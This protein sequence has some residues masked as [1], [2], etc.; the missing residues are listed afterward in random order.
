MKTIRTL[1]LVVP[2][3]WLAPG[4]GAQTTEVFTF[5]NLNR[6]VPDGTPAGLAD[7]R[8]VN[9]AIANLVSVRVRL[10]VTGSFSGDLYAYVLHIN[11]Q[12]TN[13]CVLLNRVGRRAGNPA[14][15]ND[16]GLNVTFD[17][18]APNDI[19]LYRSITTPAL[20]AQ[21]TGSW[22]P[23][24]RKVDPVSVLDSSPRTTTL[25]SFA[26]TSGDGEWTLFLADMDSGASHQL[27]S[28][29]LELKG[30]VPPAISWVTPADIV[31]GTALGSSQLNASA[32]AVAGTYAYTPAAG[33]ILNAG[34]AQTLSVLFTP[35]DTVN[36]SPATATVSLNVLKKNLLVRGDSTNKAY[37][38]ANPPLT[39]TYIGFI[40][41]DST[42]KLTNLA[43]VTTPATTASPAGSYAVT[44]S[45]LVSSNYTPSYITGTLNITKVPLSITADADISTPAVDTFTKVYNG[46]A[47]SPFTV[48]YSGFVN[49][50]TPAVLGGTLTF[51]GPGATADNVG[52]GY[53]VTPGG[54]TSGNY[55]ITFVSGALNITKATLTVTADADIST[56]AVDTFSKVYNGAS[57][58]P[59][60]VRYS[61]FVNGETP[62]VL[63]GTLTFSGP[64][65]AA[66]N[67]GTGYTVTPGG[68][69]SSNYAITFVS[70][71]LNITKAPLTIT[72]DADITTPAVDTFTK[73]YNGLTFSPFTVRYS[74]FVNSETPAVLSGALTFSGPAVAAVNAG[75]GY[76][77]MPG[78]LTSGNYDITF[79][80]GAL[81]ITKALLTITPNNATK[82]FGAPLPVFTDTYSGWVGSDGIGSLTAP[83]TNSTSAT[84]ISPAGSYAITPS[85]AVST[86]YAFDYRTG[87]LT[88]TKATSAAT[89][90]SSKNPAPLGAQVTFTFTATAVAPG[91]GTPDGTV[92]FRVD[93]TAVASPTLSGGSAQYSSSTLSV[94]THTITADYAGSDN[95]LGTSA[96]LSPAQLINTVN[97]PPVA[98][99]DTLLRYATNGAKVEI[100]TLLANDTDADGDP[101]SFVDVSSTSA[102]GG[103]VALQG[104][105][106]FYTPPSGFTNVDSFTYRITDGRSAP[107]TGT[108]NVQLKPGDGPALNLTIA[109]LGDG[110]Y[111]L[112]FYGIPNRSCRIEFA[113][114]IQPPSWQTLTRGVA[115]SY[116]IFECTDKPSGGIDSRFYRAV[117]P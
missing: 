75:S 58:S 78:G 70:G 87:T 55:D 74:G 10:N 89:L 72:A 31:Y 27:V 19:H 3:L 91:G 100:T 44:A 36:Y 99:A 107:V 60:T 37:G 88:I 41:G 115:D 62:G 16:S 30:A 95:F 112:R 56:P 66:V 113:P 25:T 47:F 109:A 101:I 102:Q 26:G 8:I 18:A 94:G 65:A 33:T 49:G 6:A 86:N 15:Y 71:A 20:G 98:G 111:R 4:V 43:T 104:S 90:A 85:G 117:Y 53:L 42:N 69:T 38:A 1:L 96:T 32:G 97:T 59:F 7:S 81:N 103:S 67:V 80:P 92:T 114:A 108:V 77:V 11:E 48:R 116:G 105:W 84:A 51:S 29:E 5:A 45:G 52:T 79:V 24:G 35:T 57:F 68:L 63:G 64:G 93:G 21:L 13:I 17:S 39:A 73:V 22:Q 106:I 82:L 34:P 12:G 50:E 23:D 2:L 14:G 40:T 61:G 46:L 110:S 54:L 83:A 76:V 9:S 28:W